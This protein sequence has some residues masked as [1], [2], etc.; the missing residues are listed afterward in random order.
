MKS[1]NHHLS[2]PRTAAIVDS[3]RQRQ[4]WQ[5]THNRH[6]NS[7]RCLEEGI[8][9]T[10][11]MNEH[12]YNMQKS[13]RR[14]DQTYASRRCFRQKGSA[15][16]IV[17]R[18][19]TPRDAVVKAYSTFRSLSPQHA[20]HQPWRASFHPGR[21]ASTQRLGGRE[22]KCKAY[23]PPRVD[24]CSTGSSQL[25]LTGTRHR[26]EQL[27]LR[28][29]A[30]CRGRPWERRETEAGAEGTVTVVRALLPCGRRSAT[31]WCLPRA[32]MSTEARGVTPSL[33]L[34]AKRVALRSPQRAEVTAQGTRPRAGP[35][36]YAPAAAAH[37]AH[38][39]IAGRLVRPLQA[40]SCDHGS[41]PMDVGTGYSPPVALSRP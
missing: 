35:S 22:E 39:T 30:T 14:N 23:L 12:N 9:I 16:A 41:V 34:A 2:Q 13:A 32:A 25:D 11:K 7:H 28:C 26:E 37:I 17:V 29:T 1:C 5:W 24:I 20:W 6:G 10:L 27:L 36:P 33:A 21:D 18:T 40:C 8:E 31:I 15:V 4:S 19:H 38:L 3:D